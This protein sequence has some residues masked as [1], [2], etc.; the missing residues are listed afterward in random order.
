MDRSDSKRPA[1]LRCLPA[2]D[3]LVR[4]D[5]LAGISRSLLLREARA[6]LDLVR[7]QVDRGELDEREVSARFAD[8]AG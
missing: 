5:L 7:A 4:H 6:M 2:V 1:A 3:Q 8:G